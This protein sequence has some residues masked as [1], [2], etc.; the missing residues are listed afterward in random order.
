MEK[1]FTAFKSYDTFGLLF[2]NFERITRDSLSR[3]K[4]LHAKRRSIPFTPGISIF[5]WLFLGLYFHTCR[6]ML[7]F[8]NEEI[9]NA[10]RS[11]LGWV[12]GWEVSLGCDLGTLTPGTMS[13][14][15]LVIF[16][17]PLKALA[18]LRR[19]YQVLPRVAAAASHYF[20]WQWKSIERS[21]GRLCKM[22]WWV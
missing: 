16:S 14:R 3:G 2:L 6:P 4:P 17:F 7:L 13:S 20:Q 21:P 18:R 11:K 9:M 1:H 12:L 19:E 10:S 22:L 5:L 15:A 8:I